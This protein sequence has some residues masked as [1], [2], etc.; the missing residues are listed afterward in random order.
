MSAV[1][2]VSQFYIFQFSIIFLFQG[3]IN[4]GLKRINN[5]S[6]L[7][8]GNHSSVWINNIFDFYNFISSFS[9]YNLV[10]NKICIKT[11]FENIYKNVSKMLRCAPYFQLSSWCLEMCSYCAFRTVLD[12]VNLTDDQ[13]EKYM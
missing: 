3:F 11:V 8:K 1:Q 9:P 12:K 13:L 4:H 2:I 10:S 7:N 5:S 6:S